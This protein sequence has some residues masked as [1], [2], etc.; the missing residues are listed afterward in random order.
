MSR[1]VRMTPGQDLFLGGKKTNSVT[2]IINN[3]KK[4]TRN[5]LFGYKKYPSESHKLFPYT[6][7]TNRRGYAMFGS[8]V[9]S[10]L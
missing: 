8:F 9:Y 2:I 1:H 3:K 4:K 6:L 10:H 5:D 7:N